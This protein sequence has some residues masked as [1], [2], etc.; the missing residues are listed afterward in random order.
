MALLCKQ[1]V[2]ISRIIKQEACRAIYHEVDQKLKITESNLC[3]FSSLGDSCRGDSGGGL[4]VQ[5][6]SEGL[7]SIYL[8]RHAFLNSIIQVF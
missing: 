8:H 4:V 5:N 3:A 6:E 7:V 2:V 1:M